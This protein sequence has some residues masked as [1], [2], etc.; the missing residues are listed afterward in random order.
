MAKVG[1]AKLCDPAAKEDKGHAY[2][3]YENDSC[4]QDISRDVDAL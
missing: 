2:N 3:R 1:V 4:K